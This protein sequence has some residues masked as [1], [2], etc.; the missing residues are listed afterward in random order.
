M[1]WKAWQ[2]GAPLSRDE[3]VLLGAMQRHGP[4]GLEELAAKIPEMSSEKVVGALRSLSDVQLRN[5]Q[6]ISLVR[7]DAS[8]RWRLE[9]AL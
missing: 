1:C 2:K 8:G 4:M 3:I 5:G 6:L 9:A 7:R